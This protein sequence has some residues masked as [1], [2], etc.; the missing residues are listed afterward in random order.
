MKEHYRKRGRVVRREGKRTVRVDEAGEA[1]E[2]NGVF[3]ARALPDAVDDLPQ[4]DADAVEEAAN[5][6]EALGQA[7]RLIIS[8]GITE[9]E[10][11]GVRW[12]E[13]TRR[14]HV[15]LA[16]P[17]I[18]ALIDLADFDL[19]VIGRV[20]EA[21]LRAGA[22]RTAPRAV[23]LAPH[24]GAA[25]LPHLQI[26]MAQ[27]PAPRDGKGRPVEERRVG[28]TPP[29]WFRPTYRMRP[30]RAWFNLRVVDAG[31]MDKAVPE[32]IALLA[33]VGVRTVRLL[34][35]DGDDV[36]PIAARIDRIAGA[37][38]TSRWFPYGAGAFG[39]ELML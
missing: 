24:V 25:L 7:E 8:E 10:C 3:H 17:P 30:Q 28:G 22:E 11:D 26:E 31:R 29:N 18:R 16:R 34:C 2:D 4:P 9:H 36:Y 13:T 12:R 27:G 1:F 5:A 14:V 39:A 19:G 35:V 37:R 23:R 21:L 38:A 15:S 20:S 6:I 32:A 33:P